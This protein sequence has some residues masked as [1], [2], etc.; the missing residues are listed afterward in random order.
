MTS[1]RLAQDAGLAFVD[2][3]ACSALATSTAGIVTTSADANGNRW[4]LATT[5]AASTGTNGLTIG[6][7]ILSGSPTQCTTFVGVA[8]ASPNAGTDELAQFLATAWVK[9]RM[10][11][12]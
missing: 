6:G 9:T 1:N 12:R 11:V 3:I 4:L 8:A 7:F 10:V 2:T 5:E